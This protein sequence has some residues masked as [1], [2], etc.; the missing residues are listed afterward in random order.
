MKADKPRSKNQRKKSE[1]QLS[2][3]KDEKKHYIVKYEADNW[4][5][6]TVCGS[7]WTS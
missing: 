4:Y 2:T 3:V 1:K 6:S 5:C 7:H